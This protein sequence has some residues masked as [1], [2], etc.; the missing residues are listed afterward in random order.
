MKDLTIK[1]ILDRLKEWAL[2]TIN[3]VLE[4]EV[5]YTQPLIYHLLY[6]WQLNKN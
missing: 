4:V 3:S 1:L 6:I 5:F 2:A